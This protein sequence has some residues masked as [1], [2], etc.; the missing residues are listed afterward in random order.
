M[1]TN[2]VPISLLLRIDEQFGSDRSLA[3]VLGDRHLYATNSI[4]AKVRDFAVAQGYR[5]VERESPLWHAYQALPLLSLHRIMEA[6]HIP[7]FDNVS[8]LRDVVAQQPDIEVSLRFLLSTLK[9]NYLLH[10][11]S[12]CLAYSVIHSDEQILSRLVTDGERFVATSLITEAFANAVE[13]VAGTLCTSNTRLLLFTLNSYMDYRNDR[14]EMLQRTFATHGMDRMFDIVFLSY[15]YSNMRPTPL[16]PEMIERIIRIVFA[17]VEVNPESHADL[18]SMM[19]RE[20]SLS[21]GFREDTSAAYFRFYRCEQDFF[22][23]RDSTFTDDDFLD[24]LMTLKAKL[25]DILFEPGEAIARSGGSR[26]GLVSEQG[27]R[28]GAAAAH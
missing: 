13:R 10:E 2:S 20:F 11:S 3:D 9:K 5:Y 23:L 22:K 28:T 6:K 8:V 1:S 27:E 19:N 25:K 12:H 16:S 15:W 18:A 26:A 21:P 24:K 4:F 14:R 7:Y 17:G